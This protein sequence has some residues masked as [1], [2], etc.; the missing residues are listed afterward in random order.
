[1]RLLAG[2]IVLAACAAPHASEPPQPIDV[3]WG[4]SIQPGDTI[5]AVPGTGGYTLL[6]AYIDAA[7]PPVIDWHTNHDLNPIVLEQAI[8][9]AER[10]GISDADIEGG[11]VSFGLWGAGV[12][13]TDHFTYRSL[14]G[15]TVQFTVLGGESVCAVGAAFQN[16]LNYTKD[17][18]DKDARDLYAR[19]PPDT[20]ITIVSHS[21]GGAVS[22]YLVQ[23]IAKDDPRIPFVVAAGVPPALL[24]YSF[25]G[26]GLRPVG[27]ASVYEVDRPDDPIHTLHVSWDIEGHQYDIMYGDQFQ[28]SYG[29]TTDEL[30]CHGVPG[31]CA[32]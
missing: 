3:V 2:S 28:G 19:L 18:A 22:E 27:T 14:G 31:P 25:P 9:A 6:G 15:L 11:A 20:R 1:M 12:T 7:S 26:P 13:S 17:S 8:G 21:W 4:E 29:I 5:V 24:D 10:A 16:I 30:S 23:E 32:N